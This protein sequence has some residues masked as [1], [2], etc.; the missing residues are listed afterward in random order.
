MVATA[1]PRAR[2]R[3]MGQARHNV[4]C[5]RKAFTTTAHLMSV[6]RAPRA[7]SIVL[8]AGAV[9]YR[10]PPKDN[11]VQRRLLGDG[12][13]PTLLPNADALFRIEIHLLA[14]LHGENGVPRIEV[15]DRGGPI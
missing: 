10:K 1:N 2:T 12:E 7:L 8:R 11:E 14:G 6:E 13:A 9:G 5:A 3:S 4:P 15:A